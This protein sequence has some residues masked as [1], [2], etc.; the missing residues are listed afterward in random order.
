[1]RRMFLILT[2]SLMVTA[3]WDEPVKVMTTLPAYA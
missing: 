1:M 3:A 2:V